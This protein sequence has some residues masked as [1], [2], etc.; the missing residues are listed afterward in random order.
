[1]AT[2]TTLA[3]VQHAVA[4]HRWTDIDDWRR[5]LDELADLTDAEIEALAD[6]RAA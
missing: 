4:D 6:R 2:P 5:G 1:M 3:H